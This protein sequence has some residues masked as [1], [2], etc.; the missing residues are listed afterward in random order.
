MTPEQTEI[1][2]QLREKLRR[3]R[4]KLRGY[5]R[6][7][8]ATGHLDN[9]CDKDICGVIDTMNVTIVRMDKEARADY[10]REKA[11]LRGQQ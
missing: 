6:D 2:R 11:Q 5:L 7:A 8:R 9:E 4:D 10:Q 3:Q 1:T